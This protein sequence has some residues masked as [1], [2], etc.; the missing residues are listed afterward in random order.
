MASLFRDYGII[1]R[2]GLFDPAYYLMTYPDVAQRNIDP[3]IHYLEEGARD[4]LSPNP[5]FDAAYY[6][7]QCR[8]HGL[9]PENP[10]LHYL[11]VGMGLGLKTRAD[12]EHQSAVQPGEMADGD[13]EPNV[14]QLPQ[15]QL[16]IDETEISRS[17]ILRV[18]GWAVCF[19]PIATI[20]VLLDGMPLGA[21]E[22]G[23]LRPDVHALR[24]DY[25]NSLNSGFLFIG[26]VSRFGA[27]PKTMTV[28]VVAQTGV[29]REAA[30]LLEVPELVESAPAIEESVRY[31]C[32][33]LS[34]TT[35]GRVL[36]SG[37]AVTQT[38]TVA[39]EVLLDGDKLGYAQLGFERSDVGN[40]FPALPH[41][42][43]SGFVAD[44]DAQRTLS[45]EHLVTLNVRQQDGRVEVIN[46]P[47]LAVEAGPGTSVFI[48]ERSRG[49]AREL[50]LDTPAFVGGEM[51]APVRGNLEV[52]GWALARAG[53]AAIEIAIDDV[54]VTTADYG[55]RRIDVQAAYPDW[56]NSLASG[57]VALLPHRMLPQGAHR[58]T[59]TLRDNAGDTTSIDFRMVVEP[60][61]DDSGPW[62][63]RRA[64]PAAE[65]E[66]GRRLLARQQWQPS[67]LVLMRV[68]SE[69]RLDDALTTIA[70][71]RTQVY[72]CWRLVVLGEP[73]TTSDPAAERLTAALDGLGD[74]AQLVRTFSARGMPDDAVFFGVLTPGTELGCDALQ[75]IA[76]ASAAQRDADF[77]YSDE[78]RPDPIIGEIEAFF[79]P[80]WSP[81]L[82]L[83]TNY[84]GEPWYAHADL[85]RAAMEVKDDLALESNYGLVLRLTEMAKAIRHVP[86]VLC[87]RHPDSSDPQ[88]REALEQA[89]LR[90]GA[91]EVL[92]G[93]VPGSYRVR[94]PLA[95]NGLV[96]I[97]IPT[98]AT[99]GMIRRCIETIRD[100]TAYRNF[101]IVC[102]E[103][104][105]PED[106]QWRQWLQANA[107]RVVS[108]QESFNWSR[109][110]NKAATAARGQF[111]LFLNDDIE[112]LD[113]D[114][115]TV[116]LE[117]VQR[118]EIG[119]VGP[120]LLY[121]DRRI[122]HA[123]MFL[124]AM[125][126]AR[127]AFRY[128][129]EH[130]PGYF[131][132]ALTERNVMAVTGACLL[133]RR[134][135]FDRL[136][137]F[138]EAHDIVNNDLDYCLRVWQAG[139]STVYTP[140]TRLIH[141][142]AVSRAAMAD[143]FDSAAFESKW[144]DVFLRGDPFFSPHLSK[145]RD[146][147]GPDD[148][149]NRIVVSGRPT[150]LRKTIKK[151]LVVKLDHIGDC[152]IAFP[153]V[154]RLKGYFPEARIEV[155]TSRASRSVWAL[156]PTVD[157]TIE[158]DFFHARSS[159]GQVEL[160][161]DDWRQLRDRLV[162]EDFDLA[163]DL[164]KHL[165]TRT[166]LQHTG[167]RYRAGID[168][169][170]KFP[171]LDVALEWTGDQAYAHKRQH[172][173]DDLINLVDAI[174]AS[175]EADRN[176]IAPRRRVPP[177]ALKSLVGPEKDN[178]VC[179]HPTAGNEMK[180]WPIAYFAAVADQLVEDD[181]VR[182][183][184]IGGPG[185]EEIG[186]ELLAQMR[187]AD[188]AVSLIGKISLSDLPALVAQCALFLGNDS[189]PKHIAAGMGVPTV[190]VHSGTV[191]VYE[192]GPI[193]T[194]AVAVMRDV[195]C[196]PCYLPKPE[197]CR[198]GL[199]C[200]RQLAPEVVYRACKKMLAPKGT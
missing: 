66:L 1:E 113:P 174:A 129:A 25:P 117:Q 127:H 194:H 6:L 191:D 105:P 123:G 109:F 24:P 73:A 143:D 144:R 183:V 104:I 188:A 75:E 56:A 70:S 122:Q 190:A 198:R 196:A 132:L 107:D 33:H 67:F 41:A 79:K 71:L 7:T 130:D 13:A 171:W 181:G 192:W 85:V 97:I 92:P 121:P 51:E 53:V 90:R 96:S 89:V 22:I 86:A 176:L 116:L 14:G 63:L 34:L 115:L 17:G 35:T 27:G 124:A 154:R 148:E 155:L 60:L 146:S 147:V 10:L 64:M 142:E 114:W 159:L 187:R 15:L 3:L 42:L 141:Y 101:E 69:T 46:L 103:N 164:R 158:F 98:R 12:A 16:Y 59:V 39:I 54:A 168:Y 180:Q 36:L 170:G 44:Y 2:S 177:K 61:P 74:Q 57:Y 157:A 200:L 82:L 48:G 49:A 138:D 20:D 153:A 131:G 4:S 119:I 58:V 150:L 19:V 91:G 40:L 165:E 95:G 178:L 32:D 30:R 8:Q 118:P 136:G 77:L 199:V 87:E 50:N 163:V 84:I 173:A 162:P 21:A 81:D 179:L 18:I 151:I 195:A 62:A 47:T 29:V 110:N 5:D 72:P 140:H 43:R 55:T 108:T 100:L 28:R 38:G 11:S 93:I 126:Q 52:G 37:W 88:E 9:R 139:L 128:A 65:V 189:G 185:D 78:R 152:I 80:Q 134:E 182:I 83:A 94:R 68:G 111:L 167:A 31:H 137:G 102:I 156:E 166:V 169:R 125:G 112:I 160:S 197:D 23:R 99:Q 172:T 149:P 184:V 161:D 133:T 76:L 26:E 175:C 186:A 45:G 120:M 106:A 135:T 193:G 145:L